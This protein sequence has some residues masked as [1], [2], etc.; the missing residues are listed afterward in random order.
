MR[1][2]SWNFSNLHSLY[3]HASAHDVPSSLLHPLPHVRQAKLSC[4][5]VKRRIISCWAIVMGPTGWSTTSVGGLI[6]LSRILLRLMPPASC[7]TPRSKDAAGSASLSAPWVHFGKCQ[8]DAFW[9][10]AGR[11]SVPC[12]WAELLEPMFSPVPLLALK[13]FPSCPCGGQLAWGRPSPQA[14]QQSRRSPPASRSS[15]KWWEP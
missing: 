4:W 10:F 3:C 12:S 1:L 8:M 6:A 7:W 9:V 11:S 2:L 15:F 14:W 5:R 13:E